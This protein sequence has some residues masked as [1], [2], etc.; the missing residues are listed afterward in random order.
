MSE[1]KPKPAKNRGDS[2]MA[3]G[4][5]MIAAS[6][7]LPMIGFA[8]GETENLVLLLGGLGIAVVGW[9]VRSNLRKKSAG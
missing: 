4:A 9:T 7:L 1:K 3:L 5:L 8:T 2:M 6:I